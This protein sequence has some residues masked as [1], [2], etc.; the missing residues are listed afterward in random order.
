MT[1]L[2]QS[3]DALHR[4]SDAVDGFLRS[5][6]EFNL[7]DPATHMLVGGRFRT[8]GT[9]I[10]ASVLAG[11]PDEDIAAIVQPAR[12]AC[13]R[14]PFMRS[15]Q[16]W[17]RGYPSDYQLVEHVMAQA[18]GATQGTLAWHVEASL[19]SSAITQQQRNRVMHQ[20]RLISDV[21][22]APRNGPRSILLIA[23]GAAPDLRTIPPGIVRPGDRFVLTDVDPDA[24]TLAQKRLG[25]L[26]DFTTVVPGNIFRALGPVAELG[27]FDLVL[28]S[29]LYDYLNDRAAVRLTEAVLTRLCRPGGTFYFSSIGVGNPFRWPLEYLMEWQVIE[30]DEAA[31]RAL[32]PGCDVSVGRE[33]TG[34][35]L[36][37]HVRT[38]RG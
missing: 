6:K 13:A 3:M 28:V 8:L 38:R 11:V 18:N 7:T 12:S 33:P 21:L 17:A 2:P 10:G 4:L 37:T 29:G 35:A 27:P 34:L 14:S 32:L 23:S 5:E 19:Q 25:L 15:E 36:L 30:R 1:V 26:N 9:Q 22:T 20:A 31:V 24:L 16:E